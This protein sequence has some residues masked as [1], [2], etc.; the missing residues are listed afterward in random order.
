M[1]DTS[2]NWVSPSTIRNVARM[3]PAA[4]SS[5][6]SASAEP[7]TSS[8]TTRAPT[9]PNSVS[10]STPALLPPEPPAAASASSPVTATGGKPLRLSLA[11]TS[12]NVG[13]V[14]AYASGPAT[15]RG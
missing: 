4:I 14:A 2:V 9:P 13:S 3:A 1:N 10:A 5:G 6:I 11:A 12:C 8:S 15:G 7:K